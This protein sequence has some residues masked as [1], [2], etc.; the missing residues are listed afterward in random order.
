VGRADRQ[1]V[2]KI[3]GSLW[4]RAIERRSERGDWRSA[5]A[6]I[7][8]AV[9]WRVLS[10]DHHLDAR[11]FALQGLGEV[12]GAV[13]CARAYLRQM[14]PEAL[15]HRAST[16][17][18]IYN[19]AGH[20]LEALAVTETWSASRW[21]ELARGGPPIFVML[22]AN[23]AEALYN[24]GRWDEALEY[25]A[26][27]DSMAARRPFTAAILAMQRSWILSHRGQGAEALGA[28]GG[29]DVTAF[30]PPWRSE[31]H[32]ARCA[33]LLACGRIADSR[34]EAQAGLAVALRA[35]STRN[36]WFL[37]GHVAELDGALEPACELFQRGA[38]HA[39]RRQGGASLLAWG[40]ILVKRGRL[41]EARTAWALASER[42]PE[43]E[44][45]G[46]ARERLH[47]AAR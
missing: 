2:A 1:G 38:D 37:L 7:D 15:L 11:A 6:W 9:R 22:R 23:L 26:D 8:A 39:Y 43:S 13:A 3:V 17:V 21:A 40:D 10:P 24:L 41:D 35:A 4:A 14:R 19:F 47:V 29:T 36:G 12:E 42:D 33:A 32:Y 25:M 45:A 34:V 30:A 44:A 16:A 5:L 18:D 20:Y 27:L 31:W 28:L 46:R